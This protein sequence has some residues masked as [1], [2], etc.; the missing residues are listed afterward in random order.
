[1]RLIQMN[2][3]NELGLLHL[4]GKGERKWED[5]TVGC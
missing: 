2:V 1:M 5:I 4:N 3:D